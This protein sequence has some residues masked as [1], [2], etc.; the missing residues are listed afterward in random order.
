MR[1]R[2]LAILFTVDGFDAAIVVVVDVVFAAPWKYPPP[3]LFQLDVVVIFLD[4]S[5]R[6]PSPKKAV[7][8]IDAVQRRRA[9]GGDRMLVDCNRMHPLSPSPQIGIGQTNRNI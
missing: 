4:V 3:L 1:L 6:S 2:P 8:G 9:E 5:I 7:F